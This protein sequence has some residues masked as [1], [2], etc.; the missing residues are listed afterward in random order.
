MKRHLCAILAGDIVGYSRL[1][2][3]DEAGTI[4][5]Q[6]VHFESVIKPKLEKFEGRIVK[7]MGDGILLEF[8]SVVDAVNYAVTIQRTVLALEDDIPT[9]LQLVYRMGI[10]LGDVFYE[11]GDIL[12]DGVNIAARLEQ[13]ADPGG[14]AFPARCMII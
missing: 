7:L 5:R 13:M 11:D 1:V 14:F 10:N 4:A 6:R 9:D 2:E 12:G 3:Q 8:A